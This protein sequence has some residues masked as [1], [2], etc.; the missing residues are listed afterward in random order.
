MIKAVFIQDGSFRSLEV[1]GHADYAEAGKDIVCAAC[2]AI[3]GTLIGWI[4]NNP[5]HLN[6]LSAFPSQKEM[7]DGS[8]HIYIAA[9]GDSSF[10]AVFDAVAIGLK[11]IAQ[12]YPKNFV[13]FF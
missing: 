3:V 1:T 5:E 2:S 9:D 12:K 11:T 13:T 4:Y 7:G 8:G 6:S 10:Q